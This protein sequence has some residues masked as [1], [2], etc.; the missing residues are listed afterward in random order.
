MHA[1]RKV[2]VELGGLVA[3][4]VFLPL[5][6]VASVIN[7][8]GLGLIGYQCFNWLRTAEWEPMSLSDMW[9]YVFGS[10]PTTGWKGVDLVVLSIMD[11][12]SGPFVLLLLSVVLLVL[13]NRYTEAADGGWPGYGRR[14]KL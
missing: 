13:I 14:R 12:L 2:L 3:F 9:R 6:A 11:W 7:L 8:L 1:L 5:V 10:L 4:L